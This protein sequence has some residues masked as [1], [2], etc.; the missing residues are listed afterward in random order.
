MGHDDGI[1]W[2]FRLAWRY[3][4]LSA[5]V[6]VGSLLAIGAINSWWEQIEI[7][8]AVQRAVQ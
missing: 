3:C 2:G 5:A 8:N 1:A 6:A 4:W 7:A